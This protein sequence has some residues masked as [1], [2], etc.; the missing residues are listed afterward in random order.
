MTS[1]GLV[2]RISVPLFSFTVH[3]QISSRACRRRPLLKRQARITVSCSNQAATP[4]W[5]CSGIA[6][7]LGLS[8]TAT[9]PWLAR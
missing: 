3:I 7:P 9:K 1:H 4:R 8:N 6:M 5:M 2:V